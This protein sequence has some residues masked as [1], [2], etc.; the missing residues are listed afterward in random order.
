MEV[1]TNQVVKASDVVGVD[2]MNKEGED[3]GEIKEIILDKISGEVRYVVLSFGGFL[4]LGD[5]LFALP[6][7]AISYDQE[8]DAFILNVDKERLKNAPGFDADS[9]PN[10]ANRTWE[11][12]IHDYYDMDP[13]WK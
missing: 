12:G 10:M 2:V 1:N 7:K 13:Y 9:W 8:E 3:L 11:E 5:K 4:G 6:W